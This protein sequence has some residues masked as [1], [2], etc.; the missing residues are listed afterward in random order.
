MTVDKF[1]QRTYA[2]IGI[3]KATS[4][5]KAVST[6]SRKSLDKNFIIWDEKWDPVVLE[7]MKN[8]LGVKLLTHKQALSLTRGKKWSKPI[9]VYSQR[10]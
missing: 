5:I 10:N 6:R 9:K 8:D 7:K 3:E 1:N 2:V 4:F